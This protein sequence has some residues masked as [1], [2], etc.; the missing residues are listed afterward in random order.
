MTSR[1]LRG[2][3]AHGLHALLAFA[4]ATSVAGTAAAEGL[5]GDV[6]QATSIVERFRDMP[7]KG[8]PEKILRDAKGLAILTVFKAGFLVSAQGGSGI[9]IAR[10]AGGWSGPSAIGTGGA[11]FGL[12]IG[13]QVSELVIV[14][15]TAAAVEAFSKGGNVSIGADLS[16]SAGPV[17]RN[18]GADVMPTAAVY[19][20]S[21]SQGLFA[22]MSLEGAVIVTRDDA[23]RSYYGRAV[24]PQQILGGQVAAPAGSAELRQSLLRL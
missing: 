19:T 24:T 11:G 21:L 16:A 1:E 5:Q 4:L 9:V 20:Y 22:G 17:G 8:I 10:T 15:N 2:P 23:N 6:D 13:A 14:L 18:L 12:Q 7:E 3:I